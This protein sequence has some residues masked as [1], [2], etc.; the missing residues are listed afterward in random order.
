MTVSTV[1]HLLPPLTPC[2]SNR[3]IEITLSVSKVLNLFKP[4]N[5]QPMGL[6]EKVDNE[7]RVERKRKN[8]NSKDDEEW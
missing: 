1:H 5:K 2:S 7:K 4:P 6:Q 3:I 8:E